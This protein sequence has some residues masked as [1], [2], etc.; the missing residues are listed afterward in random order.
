MEW[1]QSLKD[2]KNFSEQYQRR[3]DCPEH[4]HRER[5]H[6]ELPRCAID[7]P[8]LPQCGKN[9]PELPEHNWTNAKGPNLVLVVTEQAYL[10]KV[11]ICKS[12]KVVKFI[13]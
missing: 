13:L 1:Q 6:S 2:Q 12:V 10:S 9:H 8:E 3:I 7:H 5:D 4:P 11:V